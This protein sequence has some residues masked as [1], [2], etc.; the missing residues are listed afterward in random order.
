[1]AAAAAASATTAATATVGADR[2]VTARLGLALR[3]VAARFPMYWALALPL[4]TAAAGGPRLARYLVGGALA[5][6]LGLGSVLAALFAT[7]TLF[8]AA[9]TVL[10]QKK[11][12]FSTLVGRVELEV[13]ALTRGAPPALR[14]LVRPPAQRWAITRLVLV[15]DAVLTLLLLGQRGLIRP[16]VGDGDATP[17]LPQVLEGIG[18]CL[19][20]RL[21]VIVVPD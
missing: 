3:L 2:P 20:H 5:R 17:D 9:E 8:A 4:R 16:H 13:G 18:C 15:L 12:V 1:M 21:G 6:E 19:R 10:H 14:L 11:L 7:L